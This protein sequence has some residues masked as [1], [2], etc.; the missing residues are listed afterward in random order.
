MQSKRP[1]EP[2]TTLEEDLGAT[3]ADSEAQW[4]VRQSITMSPRD[5]LEWCS[6]ITR[7]LDRS[8]REPQPP[9]DV[10]FEL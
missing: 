2:L 7:D 1:V 6:W 4:R 8:K 9:I 3:P 5:Y 10:P